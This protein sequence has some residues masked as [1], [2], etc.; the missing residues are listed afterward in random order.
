GDEEVYISSADWMDRN[1]FRRVELA[2]PITDKKLKKRVIDEGLK[3]LLAD[4]ILA[5]VMDSQGSY[6]RKKPTGARRVNSQNYLLNTL[7][8]SFVEHSESGRSETPV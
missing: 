3:A 8:A 6:T 2:V 1:F 4:N 5:W 7:A